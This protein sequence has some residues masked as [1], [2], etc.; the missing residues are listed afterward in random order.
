VKSVIW[1]KYLLHLQ[2]QGAIVASLRQHLDESCHVIRQRM[3]N[4]TY[5]V[6]VA[7][8]VLR[9]PLQISGTTV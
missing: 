1:A 6:S 3:S 8:V 5:S 2:P 9:S 4:Y 7:G